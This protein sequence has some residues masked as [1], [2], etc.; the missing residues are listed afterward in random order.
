MAEAFPENLDPIDFNQ[1]EN[2]ISVL[3]LAERWQFDTYGL[4][5]VNKSLVNNLRVVDPEG[6]KIKINCA[7]VQ[8]EG[9]IEKC[10]KEDAEKYQVELKGAKQPRGPKKKP[11]IEWLDNSTGAYYLD[12]VKNNSFDFIIGHIPY[13]ANG[14]LNLRDICAATENKPKVILMVHDL[15]R[16][17]DEFN[18]YEALLE[19]LFEAD[20]IF[21]VGKQVEAEVL[22]SIQSLPPEKRPIHMLYIPGFPLEL[23]N[24]CRN[25]AKGNKV[26]GTQNVTMM[27][28]DRKDLQISGIDFPL[29][30][31]STFEA[32]K[33]ILDFDGVRSNFEVLINNR[34]D[35]DQW[36]K[37]FKELI[38]KQESR[39]RSLYF[40]VDAPQTLEGLKSYLRKSNLIILP[41][42]PESP[43]FGT[44]ALS[45]V[46]AGVPILVSS[47]SGIASV[48]KTIIHDQSVVQESSLEPDEE[49]WT[50]RIL[51]KL[52][53]PEESQGTAARLR[54]Q[55]LLDSS[56]AQSHLDFTR[57][58]AGKIYQ[59]QLFSKV[60]AMKHTQNYSL[61]FQ[62]IF[63]LFRS[64][65]CSFKS[66][67][68]QRL[69]C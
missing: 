14:A 47:H 59:F 30:F 31:A 32:S 60:N 40:H 64:V 49:T 35:I 43:L 2:P 68:R 48:L 8:E 44:E 26:Q 50:D 6:K 61:F 25:S 67:T 63:L 62:C 20:A 57:S 38:Q 58:V 12:F 9:K 27:T 29:A 65:M 3:L 18:D 7:V 28:G 36:K 56:I 4:S 11:N 10:Q 19:W 51:Q 41:L 17:S 13:L 52:L 24:V 66:G 22:S 53:R 54:D 45:A 23:F 39:G 69:C 55:L 15:P 33:H 5:T 16:S 21:S 34:E 46:A 37:E 1:Q 42:K